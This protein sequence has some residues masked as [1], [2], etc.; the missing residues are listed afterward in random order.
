MPS[1]PVAV[2]LRVSFKIPNCR[3]TVLTVEQH[4]IV[5]CHQ[6]VPRNLN[7]GDEFL[8]HRAGMVQAHCARSKRDSIYNI[9]AF[10]R[11]DHPERLV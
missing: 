4:S 9:G 6:A 5:S 11:L 3:L 10:T 2:S 1:V 8:L 7:T